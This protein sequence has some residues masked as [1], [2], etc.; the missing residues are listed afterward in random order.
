MWWDKVT[1]EIRTQNGAE[2]PNLLLAVKICSS[3]YIIVFST[4]R[5]DK[6]E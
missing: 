1:Q 2:D 4:Y 6:H 3:V 5:A